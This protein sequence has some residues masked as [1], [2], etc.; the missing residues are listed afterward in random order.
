MWT[1]HSSG[2]WVKSWCRAH[3]DECTPIAIAIAI[4]IILGHLMGHTAL[5]HPRLTSHNSQPTTHNSL[6]TPRQISKAGGGDFVVLR[7]SG[8]DAYDEWIVGLAAQEV[9]EHG[10]LGLRS[11]S[12][13]ILNSRR[14]ASD[15]FVLAK[16]RSAEA[17]FFAGGDQSNY[18]E[19][20]AGTPLEPL[21]RT[22]SG[23]V[24]VGGTSAGNA[25]G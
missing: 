6:H 8:T 16:V 24:T 11:V 18:V 5:S 15:E 21:L 7:E 23:A 14:A 20:I 22:K 19:R 1:R 12:T 13:L 10:G 17:I 2:R 3:Q 25:V 4:A 9:E